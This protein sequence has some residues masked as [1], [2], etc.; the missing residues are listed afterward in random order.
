MQRDFHAFPLE[1]GAVFCFVHFTM[2]DIQLKNAAAYILVLA[3]LA[4]GTTA[5]VFLFHHPRRTHSCRGFT[6]SSTDLEP[7]LA[8]DTFMDELQPLSISSYVTLCFLSATV[9]AAAPIW[10]PARYI[11]F[12]TITS[13][14][15]LV[16]AV[17]L[18]TQLLVANSTLFHATEKLSV[19]Y[20]CELA[21]D[22]FH[23]LV[24]PFAFLFFLM[25]VGTFL[26][27]L[28][29]IIPNDHLGAYEAAFVPQMFL[30]QACVDN[31]EDETVVIIER[32]YQPEQDGSQHDSTSL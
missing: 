7:E 14:L 17:S 30:N 24:T 19:D 21:N 27:F 5:L 10:R 15:L 20:E 23:R 29:Y 11:L 32:E 28:L 6:N 25:S 8:S 4:F 9:M 16:V 3:C 18:A 26:F 31:E 2:S 12:Y 22:F 1:Q 13:I